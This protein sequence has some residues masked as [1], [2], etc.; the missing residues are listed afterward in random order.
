MEAMRFAVAILG[1]KL[2]VSKC[3]HIISPPER[4]YHSS[5]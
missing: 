3:D 2:A 4:V 1:V 5:R